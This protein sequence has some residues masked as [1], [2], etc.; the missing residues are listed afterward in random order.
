MSE[1]ETKSVL[2]SR[3]I[4]LHTQRSVCGRNILEYN[5]NEI[6]MYLNKKFWKKAH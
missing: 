6:Y 5:L 2:V 1:R 4:K 3:S